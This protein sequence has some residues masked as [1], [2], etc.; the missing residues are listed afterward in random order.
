M[1]P[2]NL[3]F[4]SIAGIVWSC[5]LGLQRP[6]PRYSQQ[7]MPETTFTCRNKIVG[8]YYADPETDC[9]LFHVCVSVAG[10][11]Q[12]YKFLCPNDTAFDQESQT[13]ADWYDVDCEAATLYYASDNF[14]LYRLG[15][16]L[17]SLHYDSIRTD[18]EP[19]DH[20]QRSESND[21]IRSP[22]N[23]NRVGSTTSNYNSPSNSNK[24]DIL[25]ASSSSNFYNSR[26]N[27]K[28]DE[29]YENEKTYQEPI[30]A[31]KKKLGV[32]K[33]ARKQQYYNN[34][35]NLNNGN[36][37]VSSSSTTTTTVAP[38]KLPSPS[39]TSSS[40][41]QNNYRNYNTNQRTTFVSSTTTA[42]PI[43]EFSKIQNNQKYNS[44]TTTFRPASSSSPQQSY[45]TTFY[46]S[47][48]TP[49]PTTYTNNYNNNNYN[50]HQQTTSNNNNNN[51]VAQSTSSTTIKPI[52]FN[53]NYQQSVVT[54][55]KPT[56]YNQN[57]QANFNNHNTFNNNNNQNKQLNQ[58]NLRQQSTTFEPTSNYQQTE[59]T[60]YQTRNYNSNNNVQRSTVA[61]VFPT[62]IL[63]TTD[64][65]NYDNNDNQYTGKANFVTQKQ[66]S[67][68]PTTTTTKYYQNYSP[69]TYSS[70]AK[71][72]DNGNSRGGDRYNAQD[73]DNGQYYDKNNSAKSSQY[74]D[75]TKSP[76]KVTQFNNGKFFESSTALY[77]LSRA[78]TGLGFSPASVNLLAELPKTTTPSS[79]RRNGSPT[80]YNPNSFNGNNNQRSSHHHQQQSTT[81]R[82]TAFPSTTSKPV[83]STTKFIDAT[84]AKSKASKKSDYDYAYYDNASALE[85]DSLDLE[86]V[87]GGK[88]SSK[89]PRN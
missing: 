57:Y 54:T 76:K 72:I 13:C 45:S 1:T 20:L 40:S 16:G 41:L 10:F 56:T 11:I 55:Q 9:Q 8:S 51:Y 66:S 44:P 36:N 32:R 7:F 62:T 80:T 67:V 6:A 34:N 78:Q 65:D 47:S 85:Y 74:F 86:H 12:D 37:Y 26:N 25:R 79:N 5:V 15:S 33:I 60:N 50:S 38:P 29:D 53:Q 24:G 77:D 82:V 43:Q 23:L 31:P 61:P 48:T 14:D 71:K 69:T 22:V 4:F 81:Q 17:E 89:L 2:K 87:A 49:Q 52:S 70:V 88:E 18:A 19:Q 3:L 58:Q 73:N 46:A 75:S 21:P 39:P 84:T 42:R 83:S 30:P 28:D 64:Y 27:G 63:P 35:N 59:T 68:S